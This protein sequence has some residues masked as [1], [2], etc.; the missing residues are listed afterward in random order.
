V[1][2]IILQDELNLKQ[3]QRVAI[4]LRNVLEGKEVELVLEALRFCTP[5]GILF[6]A[7]ELKNIV[8]YRQFFELPDLVINYDQSDPGFTYLCHVG[9]F[10]FFDHDLGKSP[11]QAKGSDTYIPIR[12]IPRFAIEASKAHISEPV[13]SPISKIADDLAIVLTKSQD[14]KRFKPISYCIREVV[15]NVFE[16]SEADSCA[17]IGQSWKDDTVEIAFCDRGIGIRNSLSRKYDLTGENS[18]LF[19]I[20]PGISRSDTTIETENPWANSGFGLYVLS[21]LGSKL[22]EFALVSGDESVVC[23]NNAVNETEYTFQGTFVQ[24]RL[25]RPHG[26]NFPNFIKNIVTNG[27]SEA[28]ANGLTGRASISSGSLSV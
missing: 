7:S 22:G 19:A 15:R 23:A 13:G 20:R 16:H 9:F 17:M 6:L 3:A 4:E 21:E 18:L 2:K 1:E 10:R 8:G 26:E 27:E 24:L 25:R 5:S 12:T 11:G 28:K 14:F